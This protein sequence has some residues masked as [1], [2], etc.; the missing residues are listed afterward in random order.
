M[1]RHKRDT[2][3]YKTGYGYLEI[4]EYDPNPTNN[5]VLEL[6]AGRRRKSPLLDGTNSGVGSVSVKQSKGREG[7]V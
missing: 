3:V 6:G 7:P 4:Y 2:F 5:N 1:D